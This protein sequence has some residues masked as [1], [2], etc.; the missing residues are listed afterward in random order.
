MSIDMKTKIRFPKK[1]K[2][3]KYIGLKVPSSF[4]E[5]LIRDSY[6]YLEKDKLS[7]NHILECLGRCYSER[8]VYGMTLFNMNLSRRLSTKE[9]LIDYVKSHTQKVI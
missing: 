8:R 9:G 3:E 1:V 6:D 7:E 4:Y 2:L 5:V